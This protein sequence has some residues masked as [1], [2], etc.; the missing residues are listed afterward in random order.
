LRRRS[1]RPWCRTIGLFL[2]L[3]NCLENVTGLLYAR[4]VDPL[5]TTVV[6]LRRCGAAVASTAA[7][8]MRAHTLRFIA[9]ERTGVRLRVRDPDFAQHVQNRPALDFELSC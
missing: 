3:L 4:P 9:F 8:E 5:R 7:L 6:I 1:L 2:A